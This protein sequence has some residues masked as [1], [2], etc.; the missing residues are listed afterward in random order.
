VVRTVQNRTGER[1]EPS[2]DEEVLA[3][4][5][6]LHRPDLGDDEPRLGR[7]IPAWLD[8]ETDPVAKAILEPLAGRVP[9]REIAAQVGPF[10][11]W[12]VGHG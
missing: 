11:P 9:Q 5:L 8:L 6:P 7:E 1:V 3:V 10:F 4:S 12:L 2:I